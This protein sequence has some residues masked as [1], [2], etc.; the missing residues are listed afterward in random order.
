MSDSVQY[1]IDLELSLPRKRDLLRVDEVMDVLRCKDD[2]VRNLIT[3]GELI[4]VDN[5]SNPNGKQS[6]YLVTRASLL[7]YINR[8]KVS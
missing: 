5:K 6:Y 8:R 7:S 2:H 1:E 3:L 4:G